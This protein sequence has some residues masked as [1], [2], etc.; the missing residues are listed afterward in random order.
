V[1]RAFTVDRSLVVAWLNRGTLHLVRSEDY[2]WLHALTAPPQATPNARRLAQE[3]VSPEAADLGVKTVARAL[4]S[5]GPLTREQLRERLA[6]AGVPTG[7]QALI[8]VL[9]LASLRE[10]IVRGPMVG[11]QQAFTLTRDWLGDPPPIDRPG[12]LAEL[13]RRYLAGHG[14]ADTGDLARWSG[15]PLNEARR[16]LRAIGGELD[17]RP[18][19]LVQL[20]AR[21]PSAALPPPRLLGAFD[22]LLLGWRS[23]EFITGA[24]QELVTVNGLF[25]PFVLINGRAAA[26]WTLTNGA[27]MLRPFNAISPQDMAELEREA[28][29]VARF[30]DVLVHLT[31]QA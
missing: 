18:D 26:T 13:A 8:H 23:R 9:Y 19:G 22:P 30:L 29:D 14:P 28:Q 7:G 20:R 2:F 15:L 24:H 5:E 16:G 6:A 10:G 27:L 3:G 21:A 31:V 11:R 25:R 1:D 4:G 17:E 12:A